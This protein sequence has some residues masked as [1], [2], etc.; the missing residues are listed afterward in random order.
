MAQ[1]KR[2]RDALDKFIAREAHWMARGVTARRARNGLAEIKAPGE[3]LAP[4]QSREIAKLKAQ[5]ERYVADRQ[6]RLGHGA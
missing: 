1:A 2:V 4:H 3:P 6:A 5:S